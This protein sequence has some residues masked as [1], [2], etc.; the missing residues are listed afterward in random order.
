MKKEPSFINNCIQYLI[1]P[2]LVFILFK[3]F[4]DWLFDKILVSPFLSAI[5]PK[6]ILFDIALSILCFLLLFTFLRKVIRGAKTPI[7]LFLFSLTYSVI[8]FTYRI[9]TAP[10]VFTETSVSEKIKL[11]D[12]LLIF[13]VTIIISYLLSLLFKE[14]K[15]VAE[16][17]F[18]I[19]EPIIIKENEDILDRSKFA[20]EIVEKIKTTNTH[21]GSFPIGIVGAWGSG[22]TTLLNTIYYQLG[23]KEFIKFELNVW[24]CSNSNQIIE[25]LFKLFKENLKDYSFTINN[26][27]TDYVQNL[28]KN[29]RNE[30]LSTIKNISETFFPNPSLEKQ[31]EIINSEI[32]NI[33]KKI[34]VLID[35]LD[36]LD[37]EEIYEVI[38]LIRNTASFTNTFFIATYDRNYI[39]P[40]IES[41]NPYQSH[42]Y[43]EKI[44]QIEF[45]LPP[46]SSNAIQNI[47]T[48]KL[49]KILLK[50]DFEDYKKMTTGFGNFG[51]FERGTVDLTDYF[52]YTI[53]DATRF[54]NSLLLR[55]NFLQGE[56]YFPDFYNLELIRFKHPEFFT[57]FYR[58]HTRFLTT[59]EHRNNVPE[60]TGIYHLSMIKDSKGNDT[61]MSILEEFL[62]TQ[63]ELFKFG[64]HEI[65]TLSIA[66]SSIF[67]QVENRYA[68]RYNG[69]NGHLS[70]LRVHAFDRYFKLNILGLLSEKEFLAMTKLPMPELLNAV[71]LMAKSEDSMS[72]LYD[73]FR[74]IVDFPD[75]ISFERIVTAIFHFANL[76]YPSTNEKLKHRRINYDSKKLAEVLG[77]K[78]NIVLYDSKGEYK[79]FLI[80]LLKTNTN[81]YN[82]SNEFTDYILHQGYHFLNNILSQEE[83][84]SL[85]FENFKKAIEKSDTLTYS[86]WLHF[87]RCQERKERPGQ[88]NVTV[89]SY[90]DN[91]E[92]VK[93]MRKFVYNNGM[94]TF[95]LFTMK[96][97]PFD[98]EFTLA[99]T[100]ISRL[101]KN[102][103]IFI[104]LLRR[105]KG[106]SAY[107]DEFLSFYQQITT[108]GKSSVPKEF[109]KKIP[110]KL[111]DEEWI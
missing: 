20:K 82:Y 57:L 28:L 66:F 23:E 24:K 10:F 62:N 40:A 2:I 47:V 22:K 91:K 53:R 3:S 110:V 104:W 1:V 54:L 76:P 58:E 97:I 14:K 31:Y 19:D 111:Q 102:V 80:P 70:V 43:L 96:E 74:Y 6:N 49:E 37:K 45:S 25:T 89:V 84:I 95:L 18:L 85:L 86:L 13:P 93:M 67:P 100:V 105:Y 90:P 72:N 68:S 5:Y 56:I 36:R 109:F 88:A 26:K 106:K 71:T 8:Y 87:I 29:S 64:N 41:I 50:E 32:K 21:A 11:A 65:R 73:R 52:I 35:D 46:I 59:F 81:D 4:F 38:R 55:Y 44:F 15:K 7:K 75:K 9:K 92:A 99:E 16:G 27:L 30:S 79:R 101:F 34:V 103:E 108:S 63:R 69:R 51:F 48:I 78:K 98:K 94:D 33:G 83:I 17:G 12:F 61:Q 77:N 60:D 39:L 107:K 42:Y